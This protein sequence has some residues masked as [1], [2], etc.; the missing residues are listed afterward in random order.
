MAGESREEPHSF[1]IEYSD[2]AQSEIE[3]AYMQRCQWMALEKAFEWFRGIYIAI[4]NLKL[5]PRMYQ[6]F[7]TRRYQGDVRRM[8]HGKGRTAYS[9][10]YSVIDPTEGETEGIVY[11]LRFVPAVMPLDGDEL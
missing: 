11:V 8:L 7:D 6:R 10:V 3:T 2:V 4:E 5:M 1:R 9:L